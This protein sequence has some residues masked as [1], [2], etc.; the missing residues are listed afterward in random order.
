M[1]DDSYR[2][3]GNDSFRRT[4]LQLVATTGAVAGVGM[5]AA[6]QEGGSEFAFDGDADGWMGTAPAAISGETNPT[7]QVRAGETYTFTWTNVDGA[8]HNVVIAD[9]DGN[10]LER[11]AILETEGETQSLEFEATAEMSTYYCEV[12][13]DS[14]RGEITTGDGAAAA[15][16]EMAISEAFSAGQLSGEQ[17]TDP[18]ETAASGAA[19]F[20]LGADGN[21]LH[22]VLLVAEIEN[23]TQAHIHLGGSDEDGDVVAWLFGQRDEQD[24]FADPLEQGVSGSGLLAEGTITGDDL[25]GP[26]EGES[27]DALLDELRGETAYVNVHT[28]ANPGGEI[29]GQTGTAD[30]ATVE[31]TERVD[32][33]VTEGE[34]MQVGTQISLDVSDSNG[35]VANPNDAPGDGPVTGETEGDIELTHEGTVA[36]GN[37]VTITATADGE[38][39]VDANVEVEDGDGDRRPA[40]QTDESGQIEVTIPESGDRVGELRVRVRKGEREGELE[41]ED[42][43]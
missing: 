27:L 13:P 4:F 41:I 9:A 7:L 37:T 16:D 39:V 30:A 36:P 6:T 3:L 31:F 34:S 24:A 43:D 26:L 8:P 18:V 25:V 42:N 23:A 32:A 40:G 12:H 19:L 15:G 14:M 35:D 5:A 29:R 1:R 28:E 20:G 11:T 17:Q 22:Y 10:A 33:S 38:P 2:T 21:E